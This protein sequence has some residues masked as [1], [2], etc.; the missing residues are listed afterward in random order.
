[1]VDTQVLDDR[2]AVLLAADTVTLN[3]AANNMHVVL[4][5][6]PF[7]PGPQLDVT[8][9]TLAT[10]TGYVDLQAALGAQNVYNDPV[11]G[12]RF[13]EIL[14][15]VGGWQFTATGPT[16]PAQTVYGY[17]LTNKLLTVTYG[18]A[19]LPTPVLIQGTGDG[20]NLG[21]VAFALTRFAMN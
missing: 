17:V 12:K 2:I 6:A 10:F 13:I 3:Q 11:S 8:T 16:S 5:V 9:L 19:L 21:Q 15:P 20:V 14:P 7:V 18:G 1:M 4:I